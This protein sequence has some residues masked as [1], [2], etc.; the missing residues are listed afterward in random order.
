MEKIDMI[1]KLVG[2]INEDD[3]KHVDY[4]VSDNLGIFIPSTGYCK[5]AIT[6]NHTHPTYMFNIFTKEENIIIK[7]KI[8]VPENYYLAAVLSPEIKHQENV[9]DSFTRYY[10]IMIDKNYFEKVYYEYTNKQVPKLFWHQ[11]CVN[12]DIL[13]YIKQF[14][15][16]YESKKVNYQDILNSLSL[17]ITNKLIRDLLNIKEKEDFVS[18]KYQI[19]KV[20][21]YIQQNYSNKLSVKS[22]AD[23]ANMS[24]SH[25]ERVFKEEIGKT[26]S[27]YVLYVR[28][29]KA[30][31][32]LKNDNKNITDIALEC[33]FSSNAYFSSSFQKS[34]GKT[35]SQYKST[36]VKHKFERK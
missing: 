15:N 10:A 36:F 17:I 1:K 9:G 25:F 5:Y 12:A 19:E 11:F 7:T 29:E 32:L 20:E 2:N 18:S 27:E 6:P 24:I 3:L 31:K 28:I 14:I 4:S 23:V 26:P 35:P 21:Q 34:V 16:E 33:G 8:D 30:K 22:L 13:F